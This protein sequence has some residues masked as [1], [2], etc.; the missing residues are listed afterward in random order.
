MASGNWLGFIIHHSQRGNRTTSTKTFLY[1]CVRLKVLIEGR[2]NLHHHTSFY[3]P[4]THAGS[5]IVLTLGN[6]PSLPA[7]PLSLPPHIYPNT[8]DPPWLI[9]SR[10][11][12]IVHVYMHMHSQQA[13]TTTPT[14]SHHR[15][16]F[17]LEGPT[18]LS[19][20]HYS[21][22]SAAQ[23]HQGDKTHYS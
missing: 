17:F 10:R 18:S 4:K 14:M 2:R 20:P 21:Q 12:S 13:H 5:L 11:D 9:W 1:W 15:K 22:H 8:G 7:P 16:L 23:R 6:P 3:L 19:N